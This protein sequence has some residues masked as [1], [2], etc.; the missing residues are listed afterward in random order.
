MSR[1]NVIDLGLNDAYN[2]LFS[3]QEERD[4][5]QRSYVIDL[6]PEQIGDFPNHPFHVR[7]D[8][9][10]MELAESVKQYGVLVPSLVRP[11]PDGGYQMVSG[12]RRKRAAEL[13]ALPV[14]PCIVRDLTDDEA[15]IIM[16]DS[17]LQRERV[18]PSEK[19]FAYKMK[20]DAM[21]RQA[22]RPSKENGVPVGHD[23][24]VGKSR[25]LLAADSPDSNTQVQ[26]Y[27][28]L[29]NLIPELLDMVDHSVLKE[30][31]KLQMAL[32]PAVELSY[33]TV[34]EQS[35]LLEAMVSE[36]RT[37]SHAQAIKMR[38]FS[39][40]GRLNPDVILSIMQE[41]KPNQ[42]EQVKIA[43]NRIDRFFPAGT[44]AQKI[45]ET[46]VK[47]LELYRRRERSM[48]R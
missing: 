32:R 1:E 41:E 11:L 48:E 45:E 31:G 28:R 30:P 35:A 21:K 40:K 16:V 36:D 33:L 23:S 39:E 10:M 27:I 20:L 3:T 18:L 7:M 47:A 17:N 38:E 15:V 6:A 19:A 5:A 24:L 34:E 43:R 25:E 4:N 46:I 42:V 9:S 26:R 22:G 37:P 44:P 13:A 14:L 2:D 12:H 8:E 29:T